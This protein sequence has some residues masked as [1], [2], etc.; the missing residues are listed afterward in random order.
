MTAH[1]VV[2]STRR[3][4]RFHIGLGWATVGLATALMAPVYGLDGPPSPLGQSAPTLTLV[5]PA[6]ESLLIGVSTFEATLSPPEQLVRL[7]FFVD[8]VLACVATA[9]PLRCTWDAGPAVRARTVRAVATLKEG[10]RLTQTVRTS[11]LDQRL[12]T[13]DVKAVL[14][15]AVVT[16]GRGRF[17]QGLSRADFSLLENER[18]VSIGLFEAEDAPLAVVLTVDLSSSMRRA[19][20]DVRD[21][22]RRFVAALKPADRVTMLGFNERLYV[23]ADGTPDEVLR[24][25]GLERLS[26]GG[27]TAL[28]DAIV[29][30]VGRRAGG[31]GRHAVVVVSDGADMASQAELAAVERLVQ[32]SDATVYTI[33]VGPGAKDRRVRT[34]M[35]SL[36]EKSGGRSFA[37]EGVREVVESLTFVRDDLAHQYL[38]GYTPGP[39][40]DARRIRVVAGSGRYRVRTRSGYQPVGTVSD[41]APV[42]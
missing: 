8:G 1:Q 30:A 14:V 25:P 31:A 6:A 2:T 34:I 3:P 36:A 35:E 13:V 29:H 33:T 23:L 32:A 10:P 39:G 20:P 40:P 42:R 37:G 4:S 21:A 9:P 17:V 16:D 7:E 27:T 38:L 22:V 11:S 18:P 15:P 19:L 24:G 28:Y 12:E 26:A 5:S 41:A